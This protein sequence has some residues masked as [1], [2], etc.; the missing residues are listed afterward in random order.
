MAKIN[1]EDNFAKRFGFC[2]RSSAI[3]YIP[4]KSV[5]TKIILNNYW[6]LKSDLAVSLIASWRELSGKLVKRESINFDNSNVLVL[7][8]PD[9]IEGSCEIEAYSSSNLKIP[10]AAIMAVYESEKSISMVHSY[11]RTYSQI[12]TVLQM[13]R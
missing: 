5:K 1:Q 7:T 8:P 6:R 9:D 10:Y 2:I 3:F 11:T 4:G 12:L 13:K